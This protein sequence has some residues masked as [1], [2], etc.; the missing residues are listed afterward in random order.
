MRKRPK[1]GR[2]RPKI[3]RPKTGRKNARGFRHLPALQ[4]KHSRRGR[5]RG[6]C[7]GRGRGR[8]L[9][10]ERSNLIYG[11]IC[12]G[13]PLGNAAFELAKPDFSLLSVIFVI[14]VPLA[15]R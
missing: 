6:R 8:L 7:R 2:K 12:S 14:T 1:N 3:D 11:V 15:T 4:W 9:F 13:P 10:D 5:R